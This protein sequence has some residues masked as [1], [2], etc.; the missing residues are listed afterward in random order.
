METIDVE[1]WRGG[2]WD[3]IKQH[4]EIGNGQFAEGTK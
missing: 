2:G 1:T 4:H 3:K